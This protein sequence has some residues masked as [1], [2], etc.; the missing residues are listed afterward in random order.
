MSEIKKDKNILSVKNLSFSYNHRKVLD[1]LSFDIEQGGFISIVGPNGAG[2]STLV[3][4]IS[5]VLDGYSGVIEVGGRDIRKLSSYDTAKIIGVVPQY[6]H[7]GFDFTVSEIV[8]MG[9]YT[10]TPRFRTERKEDYDAICEAMEKTKILPFAKRKFSE[11][12]GGEK[13]RVIVAQVLAQDSPVLLLDEPTSHLDI[14]FQIE[15]MNLFLSLNRK[16]NKTIIG[17]FHDI[18]L[19]IQNSKKIMLLKEGRIFNFGTVPDV[20]SR[21]NIKIVFG[22]EVFVG[23]NPV[24]GKLYVSPDFNPDNSTEGKYNRLSKS[25]KVHVIGGG[26]AASPVINLLYSRGY[27]VSCGV[28]NTLDTDLD[29][30]RMLGIP[31]V[32]E[33]PFSPISADSRNK[34]LQ[35]IKSSDAVILPGVEFGSGNFPNLMSA[36]EAVKLG[37]KVIVIDNRSVNLRD[38]TGGRAIEL[39][40]K[41]IESGAITVKSED[42]I[43]N[44]L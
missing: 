11:L 20:I 15:F 32:T 19:A 40:G 41:I 33:A 43:I 36:Y 2:K 9:R 21:K 37:K 42:E 39:Y 10:Y 22:S 6:T 31:Y 3:N 23:R 5:R 38:H 12:S 28:V 14:N 44:F 7:P 13:Q 25:L 17:I 27:N 34:N 1:D 16:E 4:L 18:N 29:T 8:M 30:A 24:T 26:G 35:F